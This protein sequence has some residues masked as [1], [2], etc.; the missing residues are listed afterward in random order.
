MGTKVRSHD[1]ELQFYYESIQNFIEAQ[2]DVL[3]DCLGRFVS[4][5]LPSITSQPDMRTTY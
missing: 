5:L 4:F 3:G 2:F 1:I